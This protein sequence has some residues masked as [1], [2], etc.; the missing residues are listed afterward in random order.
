M[1]N[2]W[3]H[4]LNKWETSYKGLCMI[5]IKSN[6]PK[7]SIFIGR[8]RVNISISHGIKTEGYM[9]LKGVSKWQCCRLDGDDDTQFQKC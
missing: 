4:L 6:V 8:K 9:S 1:D 5:P 7:R 2:L 3:K